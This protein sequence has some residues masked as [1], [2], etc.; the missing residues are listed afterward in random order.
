M[1]GSG[2]PAQH[3]RA[4]LVTT[5]RRTEDQQRAGQRRPQPVTLGLRSSLTEMAFD[6][7]AWGSREALKS[8][9]G[10]ARVEP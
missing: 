6:N 8:L 5:L 4:G 10:P 7:S 2:L 3:G 1:F 9:P